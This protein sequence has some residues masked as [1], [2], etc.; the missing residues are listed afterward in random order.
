MF[1]Q[2]AGTQLI[3]IAPAIQFNFNEAT[4]WFRY[5]SSARCSLPVMSTLRHRRSGGCVLCSSREVDISERWSGAFYSGRTRHTPSISSLSP[6]VSGP[7]VFLRKPRQPDLL[8]FLLA[9]TF[10]IPF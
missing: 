10:S 8:P 2:Y 3:N 9:A 7:A 1:P 4:S 5:E 6:A